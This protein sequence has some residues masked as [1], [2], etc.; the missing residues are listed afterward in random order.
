[1]NYVSTRDARKTVTLSEAIESGLAADGGL[2]IPETWPKPNVDLSLAKLD[3]PTFA[4]EILKD[5]FSDDPLEKHL[6]GICREAFNFP[7]PLRS[8]GTLRKDPTAHLL[9]LFHGPTNAFKDFG[10]RFLSLATR[11]LAN[12]NEKQRLVLVATSG[13][14]GGAVASSFF[15]CS[16]IPVVIL[17]PKGKVTLR[18][19]L[20]LTT[21]GQRVRAFAVEGSFDDCQK[22]AKEAFLSGWWKAQYRLISANSINI[23]RLLP[24]VAYFA[25]ASLQYLSKVGAPAG[26]IVPSG[27]LGNGVAALWAKH[28]GFPIREVVFAHN[29]NRAVADFFSNGV[30]HP[31]PT[32]AT[33]ANAM[34]V[35]NPSN[36]ERVQNLYPH[37]S[38]LSKIASAQSISDQEI[39]EIMLK[40]H[41]ESQEIWC[42]HTATAYAVHRRLKS[43]HWILV[44]TAHPAKF[45]TII[46]PLLGISL[47]VPKNLKSV[48]TRA[49]VSQT[50]AP[51]LRS[52]Q[53]ALSTADK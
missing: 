19:E 52:L 27:N 1:M 33:L 30:W 36:F 9:E 26:I 17:Y 44:A 21:W 3:F 11:D 39:R 45:E 2:Y 6:A 15:E 42:P 49:P 20:Q 23:G 16:Q 10:A 22:M 31:H 35:G 14:T 37:F 12:N 18:Q 34:D 29:A 13:D 48:L 32:V 38:E 50:I 4:G 43:D 5:F 24:Q 28:L 7:L 8:T 46:E 53:N 40:G 41:Q 47:D 51:D 25:F